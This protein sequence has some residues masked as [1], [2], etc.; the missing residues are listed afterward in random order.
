MPQV[1]Y[2]ND[3]ARE[4]LVRHMPVPKRIADV[5][6]W[7]KEARKVIRQIPN[8]DTTDWMITKAEATFTEVLFNLRDTNGKECFVK[9]DRAKRGVGA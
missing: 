3:G 5:M 9:I 6:A 1:L 7:F 2:Q 4:S 8:P